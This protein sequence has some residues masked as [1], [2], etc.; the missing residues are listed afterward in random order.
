M[1][2]LINQSGSTANPDSYSILQNQDSGVLDNIL[3]DE[4]I[5]TQIGI[6]SPVPQEFSYAAQGVV[7]GGLNVAEGVANGAKSFLGGIFDGIKNIFSGKIISGIG[8]IF[9]GAV[10]AVKNIAS[11]VVD[12]VKSVFKGGIKSACCIAKKGLTGAAKTMLFGGIANPFG[13]LLTGTTNLILKL[14]K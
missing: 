7:E 12:G 8:S 5:F 9:G 11:G 1:F 10:N 13:A 3:S 4:S 2:V 6:D 14:I